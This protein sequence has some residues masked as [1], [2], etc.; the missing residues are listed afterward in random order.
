M[1]RW[2]SIKLFL[3]REQMWCAAMQAMRLSSFLLQLF[4]NEYQAV[5]SKCFA[6]PTSCTVN[7]ACF[8]QIQWL[9]F[10]EMLCSSSSTCVMEESI[11]KN[12]AWPCIKTNFA[13]VRSNGVQ[14]KRFGGT[15]SILFRLKAHDMVKSIFEI[16]KLLA[17]SGASLKAFWFCDDFLCHTV[18][19]WAESDQF[20]KAICVL[21]SK[22][23]SSFWVNWGVPVSPSHSPT[24][25][26]VLPLQTRN[27][28]L[29]QGQRLIG[30][31]LATWRSSN[32]HTHLKIANNP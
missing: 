7:L 11:S 18:R 28:A 15:E 30:D 29:H 9:Q 14:W 23:L 1:Y 22:S 19:P 10:K 8:R 6:V 17:C 25:H 12:E 5:R 3:F 32:S 16:N 13:E 4:K 21:R 27:C 2:A 20:G 26:T 31:Q 24:T